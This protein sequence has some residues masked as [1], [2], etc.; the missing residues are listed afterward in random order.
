ML[1]EFKSYIQ[2]T[3][4]WLR[5]AIALLPKVS[6]STLARIPLPRRSP[7]TGRCRAGG[8]VGTPGYEPGPRGRKGSAL[9]IYLP[10]VTV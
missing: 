3:V 7:A 2:T 8:R 10:Q 1:A 6:A 9:V 5:A 4:N